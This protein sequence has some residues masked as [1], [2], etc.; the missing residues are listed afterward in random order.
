MDG[1]VENLVQINV[2]LRRIAVALEGTIK[3]RKEQEYNY[4]RP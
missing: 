3:I 4:K 2:S 1:I